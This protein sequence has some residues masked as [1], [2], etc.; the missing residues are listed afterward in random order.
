MVVILADGLAHMRL[1]NDISSLPVSIPGSFEFL[2][3]D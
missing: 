3:F 2:S 1:K